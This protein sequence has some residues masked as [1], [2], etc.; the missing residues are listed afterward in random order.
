MPSLAPAP[1]AV[2]WDILTAAGS[3]SQRLYYSRFCGERLYS[4]ARRRSLLNR[5]V[6]ENMAAAN[7]SW[8]SMDP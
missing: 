7:P 4:S 3:L 1:A 6:T 8:I 5:S 2:V